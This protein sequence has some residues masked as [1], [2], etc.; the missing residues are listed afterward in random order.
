VTTHINITALPIVRRELLVSSRKRFTFWSRVIAGG[1]GF[2]AVFLMLGLDLNPTATAA[3]GARLFYTLTFVAFWT[4]L[5]GGA[6]LTADCLS[7]EKR[8]GTLGLLFLTDLTGYDVVLGKLAARSLV[9]V[10]AVLAMVPM[11]A[12]P[13]L[14]GGVTMGDFWRVTVY[15]LNTLFVSLCVGMVASVLT[16][17]PRNAIGLAAVG[18]VLWLLVPPLA[19]LVLPQALALAKLFDPT[20]PFTHAFA[21]APRRSFA[22]F[23]ASLA[24][25]HLLGWAGLM[26]AGGRVAASWHERPVRPW[27]QWHARLRGSTAARLTL[28]RALLPVNA[29][30][31]LESR[32]RVL[33]WSLVG[34]MLLL[35]LGGWL[36]NGH[37]AL[38]WRHSTDAIATVLFLHAFVLLLVA[39][40]AST[41]FND[42]TQDGALALILST[43]MT[44]A[45][46]LRGKFLAVTRLFRGPVIVV[47]AFSALWL[48]QVFLWQRDAT[49]RWAA[50]AR[51]ACLTVVLLVMVAGLIWRAFYHGLRAKRPYRAA[52]RSL[53]EIVAVPLGATGFLKTGVG[54]S[55]HPLELPI[56]FTL[57]ATLSTV[58][59]AR[60]AC[61]NMREELR[62]L[63]L[64]PPPPPPVDYGED[65]ALLK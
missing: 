9:A 10:F 22:W 7:V 48:V 63:L 33:R 53:L 19:G 52:L 20:T 26:I 32:D 8:E 25:H 2:A 47:V 37:P 46:V 62:T 6:F 27:I 51:I 30:L 39:Y 11:L 58:L 44:V 16:R 1:I 23:T 64:D 5:F 31:W 29:V 45:D 4:C 15:V 41:R 13:L 3:R 55:L 36:L 59:F 35:A 42:V 56:L 14:V 65:Y 49:G 12:L 57:V 17:E 38:H 40:D 54:G 24:T 43:R 61:G 21:G 28:R 34:V 50:A 18:I 60:S